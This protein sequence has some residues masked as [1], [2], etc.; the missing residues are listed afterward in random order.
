MFTDKSKQADPITKWNDM[1]RVAEQVFGVSK[2]ESF[3]DFRSVDQTVSAR[4]PESR[5]HEG[6]RVREVIAIENVQKP[7]A[8]LG[9]F[10]LEVRNVLRTID[11][12]HGCSAGPRPDTWIEIQDGGHI[13]DC[14]RSKN[15]TSWAL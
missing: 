9:I 11:F 1:S 4:Q 6:A 12:Q 15:R 7:K 2:P 14:I 13:T 5:G 10:H 8:T 3:V